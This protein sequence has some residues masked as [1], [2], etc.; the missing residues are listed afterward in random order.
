MRPVTAALD[1]STEHREILSGVDESA[2]AAHREVLRARA[3]LL[4][5]DGMATTGVARAVGVQR[6][7][8]GVVAV[9]VCLGRVIQVRSGPR[10]SGP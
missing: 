4:A 2:T 7:D 3:L 1:M 10:R 6:G 5:V 8:G 9:G